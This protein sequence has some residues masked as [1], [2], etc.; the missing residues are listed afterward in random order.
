MDGGLWE[1][2]EGQNKP[3]HSLHDTYG[4]IARNLHGQHFQAGSP[5]TKPSLLIVLIII[6]LIIIAYFEAKIH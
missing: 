5:C 6:V 4:M 3:S 2:E 1:E